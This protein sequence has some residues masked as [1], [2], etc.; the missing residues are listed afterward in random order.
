MELARRLAPLLVYAGLA[1]AMQLYVVR[2]LAGRPF[3][4][5]SR[6]RRNSLLWFGRA[7]AIWIALIPI[8]YSG[9]IRLK[10]PGSGEQW[11]LAAALVYGAVLF[12]MFLIAW[13]GVHETDLARRQSVK[14]LVGI[15]AAAPLAATGVGILVARTGMALREVEIPV[16]GLAPDLDG[17]RIAQLTDIH[18]GP[19]FGEL[20]LRRAV[21]MANEA[22][23]HVAVVTGD[24]ITRRGDNLREVLRILAELKADAGVFGCHGNHEVYAR[25]EQAATLIA[26]S[27]GIRYLR[28]QAVDLRFG[29]AALRMAGVDYQPQRSGYLRGRAPGL[30]QR[31][32]FN[33]LLSH[34]PDVFPKAA[35]LGF[36]LML[37]GHTH[38]GQVTV[39]ILHEHLNVARFF[40]PF[41]KGLYTERG[42]SVYVSPGL[43]TV[44][45]PVRLGAA[46]EVT[47]IKLCA[48]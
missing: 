3:F 30:V 4:V 46:P 48:G 27:H 7:A 37:A 41:T 43:G 36:D 34:N 22:R 44:G 32:A 14:T 24:L 25:C 29:G 6:W 2:W 28:Q 23:P 26:A 11:V 20:E 16:P 12:T 17:L 47:V 19:F 8:V 45:A 40:T 31:G 10:L 39:E 5:Q 35:E 33:L 13:T 18:Y 21:A 38:G 9:E 1:L 42:A 15:T